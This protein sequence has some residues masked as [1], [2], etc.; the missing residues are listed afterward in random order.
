MSDTVCNS[1]FLTTLLTNNEEDFEHCH[2]KG[3]HFHLVNCAHVCIVQL[4][5]NNFHI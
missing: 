3:V 4:Y 1:S 2:S 5:H